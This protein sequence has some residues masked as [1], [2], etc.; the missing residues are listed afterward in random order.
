CGTVKQP[1]GAIGLTVY[2]VSDPPPG[3][4]HEDNLTVAIAL[5]ARAELIKRN[6]TV[7]M[8]KADTVSC[9]KFLE[10]GAIANKAKSNIYV[11]IHINAPNNACKIFGIGCGS[12]G[13]WNSAKADS[14]TLAQRLVDQVSSAIGV[15]NRGTKT[16]D[17]LA[18]LKATTSRMTAALIEV[19]RL[20]P[21]DENILHKPATRSKAGAAIFTGI[22]K[23]V[24]P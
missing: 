18:V 23:F 3:A 22:D 4:L 5:A 12:L 8:T 11:S 16:D 2:P 6:Y 21:P 20:S 24:N 19:A 9:P 17:S 15:K 10:R 1:V 14:E 7:T 13:I